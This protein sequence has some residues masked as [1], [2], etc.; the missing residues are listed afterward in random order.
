MLLSEQIDYHRIDRAAKKLSIITHPRRAEIILMLLEN[1]KMSVT[2]IFQKLKI[3]QAEA[4]HHLTLLKDFGVVKRTREG[5]K[6]LY[7]VD[8]EYF[9]RLI[10]Y[11]ETLSAGRK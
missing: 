4:S 2:E 8:E 7:F 1:K 9:E 3:F 5:K 10:G 11:V 6:S